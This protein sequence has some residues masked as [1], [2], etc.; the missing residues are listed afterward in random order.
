V[1]T[2]T[3]WQTVGPVIL[4][5]TDFTSPPDFTKPMEFGFRMT[6]TTGNTNIYTQWGVD[7][8]RVEVWHQ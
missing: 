7:R 5:P 4:H 3:G 8:L 1:F 2:N 6:N